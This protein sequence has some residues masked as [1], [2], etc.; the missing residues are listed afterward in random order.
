MSAL[1]AS[2]LSV[3]DLVLPNRC[4][5]CGGDTG[6]LCHVCRTDLART[7]WSAGG[8]QVWPAPTPAGFPPTWASARLEGSLRRA[9]TAY[10]DHDRRDLAPALSGLLAGVVLAAVAVQPVFR[11]VRARGGTI[12]LVPVPSSASA[13]RRRGDAPLQSLVSGLPEALPAGFVCL[14]ALHLRRAV[15][16]QAG[17]GATER[18]GNLVEAMALRE[19]YRRGLS[20]RPC[21]IIDDIVTTGATLAEA[22]RAVGSRGAGPVGAAVIAATQRRSGLVP[23][24][25]TDYGQR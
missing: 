14:P 24:P 17:L 6:P 2:A 3:L 8:Q 13:R 1:R 21:L 4:A 15:A 25:A 20:T 23:L 9:L 18:A 10:K 11:E 19:R 16:D 12:A 22:A 7:R 5:A